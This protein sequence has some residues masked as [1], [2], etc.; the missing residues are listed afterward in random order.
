MELAPFERREQRE[1]SRRF[2]PG[3]GAP[4]TLQLLAGNYPLR[5]ACGCPLLLAFVCLLQAKGESLA[6]ANRVTL[7]VDIVR[8]LLSGE[9]RNV[10][11]PWKGNEVLEERV[12]KFLETLAW[13]ILRE[14]PEA[15]RFTLAQWK[16][17][18]P[19]PLDGLL[20]ELVRCGLLMLAGF[21]DFGDRCWS[22]LH[23]TLL[24]FLAARALARQ[25]EAVWLAEAKKHFWYEPEWIEVL[26]F[27]GAHV[28]DAT[29]LVDALDN[30][31]EAIFYSILHLKV[32]LASVARQLEAAKLDLIASDVEVLFVRIIRDGKREPQKY[33]FAIVRLAGGEPLGGR[34]AKILTGLVRDADANIHGVEN[35][36]LIISRF[37]AGYADAR[38]TAV[39]ALGQLGGPD[40]TDVLAGLLQHENQYIRQVSAEELARLGDAC[41]FDKL[42]ALLCAKNDYDRRWATEALGRLGNECATEAL[43]KVV[44]DFNADIRSKAAEALGRLEDLRAFEALTGLLQDEDARVRFSAAKA[45]AQLGNELA[46]EAL[47]RSLRDVDRFVRRVAAETLGQLGEE[48]AFEAL[49]E[50]LRD[51]DRYARWTAAETLGH[52]GDTRAANALAGLLRDEDSHMRWAA[53]GA[54]LQLGD[55]RAFESLDRLRNEDSSVREIAS[56][57]LGLLRDAR[58]FGTLAGLLQD[59]NED[60][61]WTAAMGLGWLRDARAIEPL[62]SILHDKSGIVRHEVAWALGQFGDK[63]AF[64]E[65]ALGLGED[66]GD[67]RGRAA[68]WLGRLGDARAVE[69]LTRLLRDKE[70]LAREGAMAGLQRLVAI[71]RTIRLPANLTSV[72]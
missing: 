32:R 63:R 58:A 59:E 34:V 13:E 67:D 26:T 53:I 42:F 52:L 27:L 50:L 31:R 51:E 45:L 62:I 69:L 72:S 55:E 7:Y 5:Q 57:T 68:E 65:L 23:R 44:Q 11:L 8:E 61:R 20:H 4:G 25:P 1:F 21:D 38:S 29:P 3:S 2:P 30:E 71:H 17:T 6:G 9:W 35:D 54:L 46:L 40:A 48:R 60:V 22:F 24:E 66:H 36:D 37:V 16:Q 14:A 12:L 64:D 41:G 28:K 33:C 39:E 56:S 43:T 70:Y 49:Y 15:N 18:G 19:E 10:T 47:A